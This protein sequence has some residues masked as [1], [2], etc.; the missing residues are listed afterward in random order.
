MKK[1]IILL[2]VFVSFMFSS[3]DHIKVCFL[4]WGKQGGKHLPDQGFNPDLITNV[5][6]KAG[7]TSQVDIMPWKR[8]LLHVQKGTYDMVAGLWVDDNYKKTYHFLE[9]TTIDTIAFMSL[10]T[11][12]VKSGSLEDFKG[13]R[14]GVLR[15]A[16]GMDMVKNDNFKYTLLTDDNLMI[17]Q[18]SV[19]RVDAIVSNTDHLLSVIDTRFPE[20][21]DKVKVWEPAIQINITSPAIRKNHPHKDELTKRF[22]QSMRALKKEG[23]YEKLFKKHGIVLGYQ[24]DEVDY[25]K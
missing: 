21:K 11:L 13:K 14:I 8:C 16:G 18:L 24:I 17:K 20:L 15:G 6:T 4:E 7:Y 22:N 5:L 2:S 23:F 3:T 1:I 10:K 25:N 12:D 9:T 19:G